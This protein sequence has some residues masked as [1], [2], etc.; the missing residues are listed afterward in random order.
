[1]SKSSLELYQECPRRWYYWA[2]LKSAKRT[3]YPRL[4]GIVVHEFVE[5]L[6]RPTKE[7]R[8]FFFKK[9]KS[10]L[11]YLWRVWHET[12]KEAV[13]N[14]TLAGA[15]EEKTAKYAG[16]ATKCIS[17]YWNGNENAG[18][19]LEIEQRYSYLLD[20]IRLVGIY[21]QVRSVSIPWIIKRRPELIVNG[22]LKEGYKPVVIVDIKTDRY[23]YDAEH[24]NPDATVDDIMRLQFN[25]HE[26]LQ[27]TMYTL[28]HEL[29]TG[30]KP[31]AFCWYHLL[32][33]KWF[34]TW[35]DENDYETL[36]QVIQHVRDNIAA[37]SFPKH[38]TKNCQWC[39][40][41]QECHE[42]RQFIVAGAETPA[43]DAQIQLLPT[44]V[45]VDPIS[46]MRLK[47]R[48]TRQ[49]VQELPIVVP[50]EEP[51]ILRNLPWTEEDGKA[52]NV[53]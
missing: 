32:S 41:Y 9:K 42:N 23:S 31:V 35:R 4:C 5:G 22:A 1:M 24:F 28:L 38:I 26:G 52:F 10:A 15:S 6:Y 48:V 43:E 34:V 3:N 25:L 13:D 36:F 50:E 16:I 29:I 12:V 21:D 45:T 51:V 8:P 39:D 27:P 40:Y 18:R 37:Q 46:Q 20:G 30:L 14:G 33:G 53:P 19:P 7:P 49:K 44:S 11:G 17:N 47:L 2:N